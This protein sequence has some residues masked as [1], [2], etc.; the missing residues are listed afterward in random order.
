MIARIGMVA[1]FAGTI[2]GIMFFAVSASNP[3]ADPGIVGGVIIG[4][5]MVAA[6]WAIRFILSGRSDWHFT[7]E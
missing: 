3:S 7:I 6:G 2:F 5:F 4:A 1:Y